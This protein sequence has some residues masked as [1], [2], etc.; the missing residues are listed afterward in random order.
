MS[1]LRE[2]YELKRVNRLQHKLATL[3]EQI[4]YDHIILHEAFDKQQME[5]A[6]DILKKLNALD[7]GQLE[8]LNAAKKAAIHDVENVMGGGGKDI[9]RTIANVFK[10]AIGKEAV[11]DNPL[12]TS[13]AFVDGIKT[14]FEQ[15]NVYITARY[16]GSDDKTLLQLTTNDAATELETLKSAMLNKDVKKNVE[17][18]HKLVYTGLKPDS[19]LTKLGQNW[20][21]KYMGGK[22]GVEELFRQL[23][24]ISVKDVKAIASKVATSFPNIE[25]VGNAAVQA[26]TVAPTEPIEPTSTKTATLPKSTKQKATSP[27]KTTT[28]GEGSLQ[29]EK[30]K[31][32]D[33]YLKKIAKTISTQT[34]IKHNDVKKVIDI[35]NKNGVLR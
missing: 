19:P 24:L 23:L 4:T 28:S 26:S 15:F 35:L 31:L 10:K 8:K 11:K 14:F 7:F 5:A 16:T 9:I 29:K 33:D 30:S 22:S 6:A 21:T 3:D 2:Q 1:T 20:L 18:L 17:D 13:L 12:T 34:N 27:T 25:S 32:D